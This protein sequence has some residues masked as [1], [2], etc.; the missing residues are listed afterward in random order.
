MYSMFK[1]K[2]DTCGDYCPDRKEE[3]ERGEGGMTW[4]LEPTALHYLKTHTVTVTYLSTPQ[5]PYYTLTKKPPSKY[6]TTYSL[7]PQKLPSK[8]Y[9]NIHIPRSYL[10]TSSYHS[11]LLHLVHG[12]DILLD[13]FILNLYTSTSPSSKL[14]SPPSSPLFIPPPP[15]PFPS[16]L[17]PYLLRKVLTLSSSLFIYIS[18][19]SLVS[20]T[21][22]TTQRN[23][24]IFT[25]RIENLI[26]NNRAIGG[27]VWG[28]LER[29]GVFVCGV[30][31]VGFF[32]KEFYKDIAVAICVFTSVWGFEVFNVVSVRSEEGVVFANLG[33]FMDFMVFNVYYLS[34]ERGFV[35]LALVTCL[36][37][38]AHGGVWFWG[39]C[40]VRDVLTGK[41]HE[42]RMRI[43]PGAEEEGTGIA[44]VERVESEG[45]ISNPD[46]T[47]VNRESYIEDDEVGLSISRSSSPELTANANDNSF[48]SRSVSVSQAVAAA[49]REIEEERILEEERGGG[50]GVGGGRSGV[51]GWTQRGEDYEWAVRH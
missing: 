4:T 35:R 23:M 29:S 30:V 38:L 36:L 9:L 2:P 32:L 26:R 39:R 41:V 33:F 12:W 18:T 37:F 13:N 43:L 10:L 3:E 19:T 17:P 40:E 22:N 7:N 28:H 15:L 8:K 21:L 24:L 25:Y 14:Y 20:H 1:G 44:Y 27:E 48:N 50:G 31:G 46:P 16:S 11:H 49:R 5:I 45:I 6:S 47:R 42:G 34:C 51:G